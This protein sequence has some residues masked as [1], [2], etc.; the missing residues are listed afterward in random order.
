MVDSRLELMSPAPSPAHQLI[1]AALYSAI[2]AEC[3]P[4]FFVFLAP[5]DVVLSESDVRQPDLVLV[6]RERASII[7]KRGIMGR[8]DIVAE[9]VSP[10]SASRDREEKRS[11]YARFRIPEYWIVDPKQQTLEV[12]RLETDHYFCAGTYKNTDIVQSE[13]A[14]CA[15]FPMNALWR[16]ILRLPQ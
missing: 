16:E 4:D 8:P 10:E 6:H 3:S 15:H 12:L 14:P 7:G 5:V 11:T 13:I 9:I 2:N 1:G